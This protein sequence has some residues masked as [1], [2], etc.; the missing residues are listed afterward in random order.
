ML[1][2]LQKMLKMSILETSLPIEDY[3]LIFRVNE[4]MI[5]SFYMHHLL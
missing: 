3:N 4:L 2:V 1:S 5:H